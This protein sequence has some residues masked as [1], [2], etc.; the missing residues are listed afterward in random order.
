MAQSVERRIGSAEVTGPIPVSSSLKP[1]VFKGFFVF[2]KSRFSRRFKRGK[3]NLAHVLENYKNPVS[4]V[5]YCVGDGIF[6]YIRI[7]TVV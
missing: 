3:E 4:N 5:L 6:L 2:Q 7:Y 1:L